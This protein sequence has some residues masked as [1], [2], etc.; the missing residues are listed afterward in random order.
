MNKWLLLSAGGILGTISRYLV[1]TAVPGI[2]G[3]GFPYGTLVINLTACLII[4]LLDGFARRG[5]LGPEGRLLLMTG[6]CGAYSTFST[7][8]LESS[9]LVA[10]GEMLRGALNVLGSA[11][12]GFALFRLGLF[13]GGVI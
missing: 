3:V 9:S 1:A 12:L 13:L 4:G 7:W 10:D 2:A 11:I 8:V 6:F 5:A